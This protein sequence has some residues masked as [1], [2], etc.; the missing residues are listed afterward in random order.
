[1]IERS[2]NHCDPSTRATALAALASPPCPVLVRPDVKAVLLYGSMRGDE[3]A[4]FAK[5]AEWRGDDNLP[6]FSVPPEAVARISPIHDLANVQ[7]VISIHHGEA[8]STVPL[9]WSADLYARLTALGKDVEYFTYPGQPH[10]FV[11]EGRTLLIE[12]AVAF[13]I[14]TCGGQSETACAAI[15]FAVDGVGL[16]AGVGLAP[17]VFWRVPSAGSPVVINDTA[18]PP[19]PTPNPDRVAR[20]ATLYAKNCAECTAQ[21][22]RARPTGRDHDRTVHYPRRLT[23]VLVTPGIILTHSC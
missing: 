2:D 10:T 22:S 11:D 3:T 19:V 13:L 12:R 7:A 17:L 14:S 8:D 1:M 18:V 23:T 5:I 4:N 16:A 20:G 6:E 9:E 15:A 21:T